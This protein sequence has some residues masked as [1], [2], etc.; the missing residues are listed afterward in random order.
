MFKREEKSS[1][2]FTLITFK[3]EFNLLTENKAQ[4]SHIHFYFNEV[5]LDESHID[6]PFFSDSTIILLAYTVGVLAFKYL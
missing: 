6:F 2:L 5:Y 1:M 4:A 3:P